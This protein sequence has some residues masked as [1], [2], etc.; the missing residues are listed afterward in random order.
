MLSFDI[1]EFKHIGFYRRQIS[2]FIMAKFLG[3]SYFLPPSA[4]KNKQIKAINE[5]KSM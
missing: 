1:K 3:T 4:Q 2:L 5:Q